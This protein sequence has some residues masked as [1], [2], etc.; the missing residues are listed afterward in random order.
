MHPETTLIFSKSKSGFKHQAEG[1]HL[2][3]AYP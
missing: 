3:N 2:F 1:K